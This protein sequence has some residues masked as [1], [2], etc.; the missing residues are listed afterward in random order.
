MSS[1]RHLTT[2]EIAEHF[3]IHHTV[4]DRLEK[5][6]VIKKQC[7]SHTNLIEKNIMDRILYESLLK[8]N[9][10]DSFLKRINT[11]YEK[12]VVYNNIKQQKSRCVPSESSQMVT[13][14]DLHPQKVMLSPLVGLQ[15][16]ILFFELL[17][18]GQ[19]ID[20]KKYCVQLDKLRK[21]VQKKWP[22]LTNKKRVVFHYDNARLHTT[23]L[24]VKKKLQSF[25]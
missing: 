4:A 5:L 16:R 12:W 24:V 6:G 8:W 14:P 7:M 20:S 11:G 19:M 2:R 17:S 10:L 1:D 13:K 25:G 18:Q 3:D 23:S 22:A 9:V 15:K 21:E